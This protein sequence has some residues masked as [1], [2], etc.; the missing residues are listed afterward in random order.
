MA[1]THYSIDMFPLH[2]IPIT[3]PFIWLG[4][5]WDDLVH[6][7]LASLAYG[8]LV[9]SLGALILAYSRHPVYI[10]TAIAAFLLVGP[11]VTAGICELSRRRDH[12]EPATFQHSLR[13]LAAC[14]RGL[15]G[16]SALL[17]LLAIGWFALSALFLFASAGS[18]APD[19]QTTVWGNVAAQLSADQIS[20]YSVAFF[21]LACA[22]FAVSV[23]SVPMI[24][25]RHVDAATAMR[26]SLRATARD[27]PALLLWALLI[28]GLVMIGFATW[29]L[30][31]VVILPLLGHATWHAY[32][33]I[34][35]EA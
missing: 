29:L 24:I 15:A 16:F 7:P 3:R 27:F 30:G 9:A 25:D 13:G 23:V 6:N 20:T 28:V 31:M 19:I 32:R 35:E 10:A 11:V 18:V 22:V 17:L 26:M 21:V 5:A 1:T 14:R 8:W 33:D 4:R 2:R 12:G 34:V